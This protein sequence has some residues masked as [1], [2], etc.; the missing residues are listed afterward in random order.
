MLYYYVFTFGRK[1][2]WIKDAT[3]I[4]VGAAINKNNLLYALHDDTGDNISSDNMYWGELTGLYWIWKNLK[5]NDDDVLAFAHYN[6]KLNINNKKINKLLS[7]GQ[8]K[9]IV[10]KPSV[11]VKHTYPEDIFALK[12]V[13]KDYSPKAYEAWNNIYDEYGASV[14]GHQNCSNCETFITT[15]KEFENY[16]TFL[17]GVLS[18]V[19]TKIGDVDRKPYHKRYCAFLGERLLTVYLYMNG[20]KS[21]KYVDLVFNENFLKRNLRSICRAM[22]ISKTPI[23]KLIHEERVSSYEK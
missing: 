7:S 14:D 12:E 11:M 5:F 9:W 18:Q 21:I 17:F 19:R 23:G 16:C 15:Y 6:K 22:K 10:R 13:L 1:T 2:D 20:N 4:E 3:P 8:Y